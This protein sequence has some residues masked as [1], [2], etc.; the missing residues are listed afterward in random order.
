MDIT[1]KNVTYI[2]QRNSPFEHKAV[3]GLSFHI[4]SGSFVA[5]I[6]HT[7][8]GKSTL[9]QHLNGLTAPSEGEVHIGD[10]KLTNEEK[11]KNM[12]ELRSRVGVVF[13][14]PEHQLFEETIAKDIAFG[15][16]NFGVDQKEIERRTKEVIRQVHLPEELLDRSP[17]DL[18]GG[19]KRRVAIAGV[20]AIQPEVLVLDEP[21]AGLDPRGQK[22][23]MDMFYELH[24]QEG[25]TT[26]LVTHSMEDALKY[27]DHILILN[28][29]KKFMEGTAVDV[30]SQREAL[31]S[32][33]LDVPEVVEFLIKFEK[34]IGKQIPFH[35][36]SM[37][38]LAEEIRQ[39]VKGVDEHE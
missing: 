4:P 38:E 3:D 34:K 39:V 27:A 2:Y 37:K 31:Q 7:G 24:Q 30:F 1:F 11:P 29:G 16:E 12:K 32:V 22:E 21:T 25:L 20:L 9:I 13:Q 5:I 10:F 33:Q 17:F 6:G 23:I 15:P 14:Y 19:Q 28:K 36:Q 8:S 18:S 26:I 35:N